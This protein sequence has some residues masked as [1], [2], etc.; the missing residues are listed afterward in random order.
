MRYGVTIDNGA[1]YS[2]DLPGRFDTREAANDAGK[3]WLA[4]FYADNDVSPEAQEDDAA[5]YDVFEDASDEDRE[6]TE[7]EAHE[8]MTREC[9]P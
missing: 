1:S 2:A 9:R 6:E 4:Q 7:G 8:R 5:G 3:D